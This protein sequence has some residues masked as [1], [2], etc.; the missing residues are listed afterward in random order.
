LDHVIHASRAL[1]L[2]DFVGL[3]LTAGAYSPAYGKG[4]QLILDIS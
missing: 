2:L 4:A 1:N 3:C